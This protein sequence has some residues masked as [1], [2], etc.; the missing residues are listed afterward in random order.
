MIFWYKLLTYLFHPFA[1]FY[2]FF[3]KL[4][5]KEHPTRYKEK[6]SKI[7]IS[8]DDGFLIWLHVASVG[9]AMSILPLIENFENDKN[10]KK[11][12]ITSITLSS[13]QVL[14]KKY[15]YNRKIIHQFL[16]LDTPIFVNKF[17]SHW[18]PN[19]A[20]F[21]D[22]EIW[23]NLI[24]SIKKKNIPLLL[25]NGRITRKTFLK[26]NLFKNSAKKIFEKF[27]LCIASNKETEDHLQAL[28]A[29]NIKSYG[30]LKFA[31]IKKD[32][33]QK[34]DSNFIDKIKNRK[35]WC[36]ASTH[37][38]EEVFCAQAHLELKKTYNNI[39]TIII[40]RHI[41][42]IDEIHNQLSNLNIKVVK[43]TNFTHLKNDTDVLLVDA[44]GEAIK[45][46][47]I[48]K[49]VFIGK[50][51]PESLKDVSGQNPIE[52][53][54]LGCKILH[55]PNVSNFKDVYEYLTSLNVA[56]KVENPKE[57]S[58]MLVDELRTEKNNNYE[59]VEKI[60][61][62]GTNTLNN[63]LREIKIYINN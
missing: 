30:N 2:L 63:V 22:S 24:L 20:I 56:N 42:R 53:S 13:A 48:S 60:E 50:S 51:L 11:I 23:P 43:Y 16:P 32:S 12:L 18:N 19:L 45:F 35:I 39:L 61:N 17:L 49:C 6:L 62:H 8:R 44:Y 54:R 40:P 59:I 21:I 26:W 31:K 37:P 27:D 25:I 33:N 47:N 14:E 1:K 57:L 38:S 58:A 36:A 7:N 29:Q 5:N 9:E 55:G 52:A 46:Y 34:L 3:R 10:I 4:N 41:N 15:S 28:G